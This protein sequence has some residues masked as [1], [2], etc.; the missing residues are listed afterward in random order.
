MP[1]LPLGV[2]AAGIRVGIRIARHVV[3][4][5]VVC[6]RSAH[7]PRRRDGRHQIQVLVAACVDREVAGNARS[8]LTGRLR[9]RSEYF[10]PP[11]SF[12]AVGEPVTTSLNVLVPPDVLPLPL[13]RAE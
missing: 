12:R 11:C 5:G 3:E 6:A 9:S 7:D 4:I 8:R 2:A 10:S 1:V 13:P